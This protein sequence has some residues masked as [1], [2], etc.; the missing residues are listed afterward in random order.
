MVCNKKQLYTSQALKVLKVQEQA[1]TTSTCI[2]A[3]YFSYQFIWHRDSI[4]NIL[5]VCLCMSLI[6]TFRN[7]EINTCK[8]EILEYVLFV[9]M[10]YITVNNLS[11]M[12]GRFPVFLGLNITKQRTNCQAHGLRRW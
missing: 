4:I 5:A 11:V 10:F 7:L 8:G 2:F 6:K 12:S 1:G 9:F 3:H